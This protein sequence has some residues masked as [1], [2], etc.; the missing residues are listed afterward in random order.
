MGTLR[1]DLLAPG[2]LPGA[3]P[4]ELRETHISLAFLTGEAV[5]KVKKP[6]D[7]GFL[8]YSTPA[9]RRAACEAEVVLNR[10]LSSDVYRGVL[11]V[12]R[13]ADGRHRV[14]L[15]DKGEGEVVDFAV[16]MRRLPDE[17]RADRLLDSGRLDATD[18][19]RIAQ[20][21][22]RFHEEARADAETARFGAPEVVAGN[23]TENF[24]QTRATI[25]TYLT[26]EEAGSIEHSQ[27]AF[28]EAHR[29]LFEARRGAGRVR[30]GHGDL[31]LEHVYL[32][33]DGLRILDCIEFNERFRYADVCADVAFLTMDLA[34]RGRVDLGERL[35]AVYARE[36][37]DYD[38]YP[39]VDFY[40]SYRAYV[41]GKVS[42]MLAADIGADPA[43][44]ARARAEAR[45]YFVL[46][47]AAERPR[48]VEPAVVAV[49][50]IIASGKST[51]AEHIAQALLAPVVDAD[52]T[53]KHMIGVAPTAA[54]R[55]G[56]FEGAYAPELTEKVYAEVMRRGDR[57]LASGR[58]VVLDASFRAPSM[59]AAA[60][61]LARRHGVPFHFVECRCRPETCRA[62][63]AQRAQERGVSD[64]RIEIF[65]AFAARFERAS[66]LLEAERLVV[67]TD[68][69]LAETL[70][71][72]RAALPVWP[73]GL[74]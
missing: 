65:D 62:R 18:V 36:A 69:P 4:V 7:L 9:L 16:H 58:P 30:D 46:A 23:V 6:V 34:Y 51:V 27:L 48:L 40:Q 57:V 20:R 60:R 32:T 55:E 50:G 73:E 29:D 19:A 35:L 3:P 45:R 54:V 22:A 66:E 68:R 1:A 49:G 31:R 74:V 2:G 12:R 38:L 13:G 14:D 33:G 11:P 43:A 17:E 39:L 10:R 61:D 21:L 47:L 8:D 71:E 41:R 5:F 52:R 70:A 15:T 67:D 26:A 53:R 25:G 44:R 28:L 64:G 42:A 37:N 63:L 59:R 24:R 72:L 56:A